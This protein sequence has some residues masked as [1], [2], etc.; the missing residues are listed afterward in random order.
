[1]CDDDGD[2]DD[3]DD[4]GDGDDGGDGVDDQFQFLWLLKN[5]GR[6]NNDDAS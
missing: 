5:N 3:D 2:D 4:D 1:M 6:H